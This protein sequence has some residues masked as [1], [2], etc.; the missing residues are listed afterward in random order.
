M[1]A[2][3]I[4]LLDETHPG[5]TRKM[6]APFAFC[7]HCMIQLYDVLIVLWSYDYFPPVEEEACRNLL[8]FRRQMDI[9]ITES[10]LELQ[11]TLSQT[12]EFYCSFER[13]RND[14]FKWIVLLARTEFGAELM[15]LLS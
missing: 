1:P 5:S 8:D 7:Y 15:P 10:T 12:P 6:T 13:W 2:L 9:L 11:F 14:S 4:L 3:P